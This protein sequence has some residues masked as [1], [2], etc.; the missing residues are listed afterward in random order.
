MK[1][2]FKQPVYIQLPW[3]PSIIQR[4]MEDELC[5][6]HLTG[7]HALGASKF[8]FQ[9]KQLWIDCEMYSASL[10]QFV[11]PNANLKVN[12]RTLILMGV[13]LELW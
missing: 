11:L 6:K 2:F 10:A 7:F 3:I 4:E 8:C 9:I 5:Q 13:P 1:L 12:S